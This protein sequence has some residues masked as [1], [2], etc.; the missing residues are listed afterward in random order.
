[1][2]AVRSCSAFFLRVKRSAEGSPKTLQINPQQ[3]FTPDGQEYYAWFYEGS[4]F[5]TMVMGVAMVSPS[6][7]R[8]GRFLV[9]LRACCGGIEGCKRSH[10]MTGREENG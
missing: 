8:F 7:F 10:Q 3:A 2:V 5:W 9:G 6:S 4:Q 1:M